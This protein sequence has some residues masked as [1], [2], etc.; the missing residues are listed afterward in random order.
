MQDHVALGPTSHSIAVV[1]G[2]RVMLDDDVAR[3]FG[4]STAGLNQAVRKNAVRFPDGFVFRLSALEF[5][6]LKAR[7]PASRWT[8]RRNPPLAFTEHGVLMA[9]TILRS[10]RAVEMSVFMVRAFVRLR[11]VYATRL[12]LTRRLDELDTKASR[13]DAALRAM[14]EAVR[15]LALP[16]HLVR[17]DVGFARAG[18]PP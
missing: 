16:G 4:V 18:M 11:S 15:Q 7:V 17:P 5:Q 8:E 3:M 2:I 1:R 9:A 14:I 6:D 12:E 10:E 13:H